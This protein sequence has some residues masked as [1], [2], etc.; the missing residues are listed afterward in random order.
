VDISGKG[1][2]WVTDWDALEE[3]ERLD[4][5]QVKRLDIALTTWSGEVDHGMVTTAH[6]A[7]RFTTRGRP[8]VMSQITSSDPRAGRTCYIGKRA[9]SDRFLRCYEKGFQ[10]AAQYGARQGS[11]VTHI[12]G[13]AVEDI[14]RTELEL[15]AASSDIPWEVVGRRDQYFAGSYPFCAD[16]LPGVEAD[17]LQRRPDRAP[18]ID[19]DAALNN[20]LVQYG[21]TLFT[22]LHA[23]HGDIGA[24][25]DRVVGREHN[26]ALLEA[27]VLLVEHA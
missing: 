13:H 9:S 12:D 10:L 3:V 25:W 6:A 21:A 11:T 23:Y 18:Q 22:A 15:K 19:L 14:Y 16:I 8:P 20:V 1:C 5:A 24:V 4:T 7:G 17:I 26:K 27:G 2:E